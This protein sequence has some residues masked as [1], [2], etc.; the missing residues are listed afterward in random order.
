[1]TRVSRHPPDPSLVTATDAGYT[2]AEPT[3]SGDKGYCR[4]TTTDGDGNN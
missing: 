1:M 2:A 3:P 4:V